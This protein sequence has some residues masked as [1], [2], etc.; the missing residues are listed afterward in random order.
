MGWWRGKRKTNMIGDEPLDVMGEALVKIIAAYQ[1]QW[2]RKP[3]LEEL[4]QTLDFAAGVA[5]ERPTRQ[6]RR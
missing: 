1:I 3:T 2:E 5:L 6:P 4:R